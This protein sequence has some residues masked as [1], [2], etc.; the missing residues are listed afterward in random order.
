MDQAMNGRRFLLRAGA[1]AAMGSAAVIAAATMAS[2]SNAGTAELDNWTPPFVTNNNHPHLNCS[3]AVQLFNFD[4]STNKGNTATVT[5]TG[6]APT[7]KG[8]SIP[9]T[10]GPTGAFSFP[11]SG[12]APDAGKVVNA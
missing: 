2:A 12:A 8:V 4:M 10:L 1:V 9:I 6:Q 5:F 11:D 7:G 3:F